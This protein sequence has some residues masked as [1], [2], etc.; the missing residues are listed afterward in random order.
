MINRTNEF[1]YV[2]RHYFFPFKPLMDWEY[3]KSDIKNAITTRANTAFLT[4]PFTFVTKNAQRAFGIFS[5][6]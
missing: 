1:I 3:K 5:I 2:K 6:T 4:Q